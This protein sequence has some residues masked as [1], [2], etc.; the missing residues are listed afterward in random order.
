MNPSRVC[1]VTTMAAMAWDMHES[2]KSD[3]ASTPQRS[4]R[5]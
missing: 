4:P 5:K 2:R 1:A 3:S